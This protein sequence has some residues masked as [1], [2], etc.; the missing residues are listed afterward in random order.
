MEWPSQSSDLNPIEHLWRELKL[1]DAK[2]QPQNL[3]DLE[4]I[5]REEWTRILPEMC[6][7]LE[8][9]YKKRLT[10]AV[11]QGFLR[12]V[13]THVTFYIISISGFSF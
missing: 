7:N 12:Q 8:T 3:Q 4:R 10:A 6:T 9:S 2:H 1:Q 13:L 11:Q 5:F